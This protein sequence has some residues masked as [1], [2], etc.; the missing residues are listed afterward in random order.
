MIRLKTKCFEW[1]HMKQNMVLSGKLIELS[2][3]QWGID[4]QKALYYC[5]VLLSRTQINI[6]F[7]LTF[8][9]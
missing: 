2:V 5:F 8:E 7:H 9:K 4:Y 6:R 3:H 1:Y